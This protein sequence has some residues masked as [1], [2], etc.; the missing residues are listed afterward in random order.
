MLTA[1][2]N[3]SLIACHVRVCVCVRLCV[4][5]RANSQL[6]FLKGQL[7]P[8]IVSSSTSIH[9]NKNEI[10]DFIG[11]LLPYVSSGYNGWASVC[12]KSGKFQWWGKNKVK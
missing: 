2:N 5:V 8:P 3:L 7:F 9:H 6:C 4:C 12:D 11:M 1:V 10:N